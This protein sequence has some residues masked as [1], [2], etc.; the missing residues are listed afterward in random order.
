VL[1]LWSRSPCHEP[2]NRGWKP[3]PQKTGRCRRQGG[4]RRK[5]H[6]EHLPSFTDRKAPRAFHHNPAQSSGLALHYQRRDYAPLQRRPPCLASLNRGWLVPSLPRESRSH[7]I[8]PLPLTG[9]LSFTSF[10]R[11]QSTLDIPG[12]EEASPGCSPEEASHPPESRLLGRPPR[13]PHP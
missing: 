9:R 11:R 7:H 5:A 8:S 13:C 4:L 2:A 10:L 6:P 1:I 3:L 12:A